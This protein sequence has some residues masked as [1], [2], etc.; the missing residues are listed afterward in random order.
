MISI[1]HYISACRR[2]KESEKTVMMMGGETECNE[3][4]LAQNEMIKLEKEY[5]HNEVMKLAMTS[6]TLFG[7][8]LICVSFY[9]VYIK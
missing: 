1:I 6:I 4:I 5:Y 3:M 8:G 2:L 9:V 7:V